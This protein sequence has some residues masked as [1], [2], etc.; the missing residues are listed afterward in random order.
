MQKEK[1]MKKSI[2]IA[3]L[4]AATVVGSPLY[5]TAADPLEESGLAV[6]DPAEYDRGRAGHFAR[7]AEALDLT[8]EQQA[9][10]KAIRADEREKVEPLL[11]QLRNGREELR[12]AVEKQ[13]FDESAVRTL[14][15]GQS[16]I[17]T[18]LIVSKAR[19][20][21]RIHALL[22]PAQREKAEKLRP[23][24]EE[25]RGHKGHRR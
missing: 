9:Q 14:A 4:L 19:M 24:M 2:L 13:P 15:A 17:R 21:N 7:L 18:E 22:T 12:A 10:I 6:E 20:K 3:A 16:E 8:P 23:L 25:R 5:A 11:Q 1:K